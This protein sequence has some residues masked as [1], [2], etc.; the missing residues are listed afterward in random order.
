MATAIPSAGRVVARPKNSLT[1]KPSP[2]LFTVDEYYRLGEIG[3]L[4]E[5]DR[6]ELMHGIIVEKPVINHAH[7]NCLRQL[8]DLLRPLVS[9]DFVFDTQGPIEFDDS[10][11]EPDIGITVGPATRYVDRIARSNEAV[12]VV[13]VADSSLEYDRGEKLQMYATAG[14]PVYWIVNLR[15]RIVEVYTQPRGGRTPTY[16]RHLD[17]SPGQA[18][19]VVLGKKAVGTIPVSEILP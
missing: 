12:L 13:E 7:K 14:V 6:C 11:P 10:V 5:N 16:R 19:P 17:F 1:G 15:E 4:T 9:A 8:I 3:F 18:V 2:R